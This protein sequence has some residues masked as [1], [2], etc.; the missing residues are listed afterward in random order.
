MEK[1][2]AIG[3]FDIYVEDMARAVDFYEAVFNIKLEEI[4]DPSGESVMMGFP[5]DMTAYGAGGALVSSPF[6]QPGPGGTM[7]YFAAVDCAE[8][9][10]RVNSAGGKLLRPKFPIGEFG[11]ISLMEDSEGNQFG[12]N[13][14]Q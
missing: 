11:W 5:A 2:N 3:W 7:I 10:K 8:Q 13:S 9:E 14:M 12:V 1:M 4:K 6:G